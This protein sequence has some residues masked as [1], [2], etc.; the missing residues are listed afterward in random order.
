ELKDYKNEKVNT[1]VFGGQNKRIRVVTFDGQP[2]NVIWA[3]GSSSQADSGSES[4]ITGGISDL[5][6]FDNPENIKELYLLEGFD[7]DISGLA[8]LSALETLEVDTLN[9]NI[10][11][12]IADAPAGLTYLRI[13]GSNTLTGDIA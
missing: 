6:N 10:T 11:G 9:T 1:L 8:F 5:I 3:D 12:D 4:S 13:A 7:I 2:Y